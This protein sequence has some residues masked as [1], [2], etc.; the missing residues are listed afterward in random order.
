MRKP[1]VNAALSSS[2]ALSFGAESST[3]ASEDTGT[4]CQGSPVCAADVS[5]WSKQWVVGGS[6]PHTLKVWGAVFQQYNIKTTLLVSNLPRF[7][8]LADILP[9]SQSEL[10][11]V[12]WALF[13]N[14]PCLHHCSRLSFPPLRVNPIYILTS[15][16]YSTFYWFPPNIG[17][18]MSLYVLGV[19]WI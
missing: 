12:F 13:C 1:E 8:S 11:V 18:F 19:P 7:R 17:N 6:P 4:T 15:H 16:Q 5:S 2:V 3:S 14:F 9:L 10:F